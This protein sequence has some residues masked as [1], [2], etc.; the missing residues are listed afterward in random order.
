[1]SPY[2]YSELPDVVDAHVAVLLREA[3]NM[4]GAKGHR[5][6]VLFLDR[7]CGTYEEI[8]VALAIVLRTVNTYRGSVAFVTRRKDMRELLRLSGLRSRCAPFNV[9]RGEAMRERERPA[10][11]SGLTERMTNDR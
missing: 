3:F 8:V 7:A 11:S 1:M 10:V 6:H 4:Y 2:L 5:H 9:W